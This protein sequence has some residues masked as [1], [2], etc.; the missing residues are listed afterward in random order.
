[1]RYHIN[2][3]SPRR[4]GDCHGDHLQIIGSILAMM[5]VRRIMPP[6]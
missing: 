3:S 2:E 5:E 6:L 1:M 4:S